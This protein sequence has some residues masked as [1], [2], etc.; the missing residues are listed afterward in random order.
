MNKALVTRLERLEH[1]SNGRGPG[2]IVLLTTNLWERMWGGKSRYFSTLDSAV[3]SMSK[4][5]IIIID[6]L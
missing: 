1:A 4:A 5:D 2:V 3:A 6:D